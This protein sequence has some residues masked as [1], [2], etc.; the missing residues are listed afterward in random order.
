M[1]TASQCFEP[2]DTPMTNLAKLQ[3]LSLD[4]KI[5]YSTVKIKEFH[6]ATKGKTYVGFSGGKDSTVLLHLVRSIYPDTPA[7]FVDTGLEYPEIREHVRSVE[8]VTWLKPEKTFRQVIDEKGYPVISKEVAHWIDLAQRGQPSGLRQIESDSRFGCKRYAYLKDAPFRVSEKC[9]NVMKKEPFKRYHAE[10]GRCPYIG[11]RASESNSRKDVFAKNGENNTHSKIPNSNPILIW[12]DK[13]IW[14][15]IH[16]YSLPYASVYDTGVPRTGCI[17]CMFGITV[18]RN[19]FVNLKT[20]H[21]K[22]WAYCMRERESGGLGLKEV[23]DYIHIPTGCN[24]TN[25]VQWQEVDADEDPSHR[26]RFHHP[27]PRPDAHKHLE[28]G[29]R[30][31]GGR[32]QREG[33]R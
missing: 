28:K 27:Q 3:S 5:L 26:C 4:D 14:E 8:N 9:C 33:S 2:S 11:M 18:D 6:I 24:Q 20:T 16:R 25:L 29:P 13:D 17:F 31:R 21:P 19:R 23:L 10:T 15:Y 7:V 30:I 12:T 1:S 22:Q 32:L